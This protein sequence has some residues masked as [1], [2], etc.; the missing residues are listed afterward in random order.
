MKFRKANWLAVFCCGLGLVLMGCNDQSDQNTKTFDETAHED[1]HM[2]EHDHAHEHPSE[3]PHH[4]SLIELGKEAYHGELVHDEKS[5]SIT[6]YVLD[7]AAK[8]SVPIKAESIL[9]NVKHDGKG[10]QF[11]LTAAPEES[12]PMGQSSRFVIKEKTLGDLL[13]GE[14][15]TAR[16]VLEIDGKSYTGDIAAHDHDHDHDHGHAEGEKHAH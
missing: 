7:G 8:K 11:A 16:L 4:G 14:G 5:G 10:D 13:H 3:G 12:D 9:V 2:D 6:V 1:K 15:T